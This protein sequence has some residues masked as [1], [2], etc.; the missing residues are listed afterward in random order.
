MGFRHS[1]TAKEVCLSILLLIFTSQCTE[2]ADNDVRLAGSARSFEGRVEVEF[3]GSWGTICADGWDL[4]DADVVCRQLGYESALLSQNSGRAL[5]IQDND[6]V[7]LTQVSCTGTESQ[8]SDCPGYQIQQDLTRESC[9]LDATVSCQ[10]PLYEGCYMQNEVWVERSVFIED[11]TIEKCLSACRLNKHTYGR[12]G[13]GSICQCGSDDNFGSRQASRVCSTSCPGNPLQ[14][15]GG[16]TGIYSYYRALLGSESGTYT[17]SSGSIVSPNFPGFYEAGMNGDW[18]IMFDQQTTIL[19]E[20]EFLDIDVED[21]L[22]ILARPSGD[23]ITFDSS[24]VLQE[25]RL[26]GNIFEVKFTASEDARDMFAGFWLRYSDLNVMPP[27]DSPGGM[28]TV[29]S[30]TGQECGDFGSLFSQILSPKDI[31][32]DRIL[33]Y[34]RTFDCDLILTGLRMDVEEPVT[35]NLTLWRETGGTISPIKS[36]TI[37][38]RSAAVRSVAFFPLSENDRLM[39]RKGDRISFDLGISPFL[40]AN[41]GNSGQTNF[42][43]LNNLPLDVI[44]PSDLDMMLEGG[45]AAQL[46]VVIEARERA[47]CEDVRHA[48]LISEFPTILEGDSVEVV[49]DQYYHLTNSSSRSAICGRD[50]NFDRQINCSKI[51][52]EFIGSTESLLDNRTRT[53]PAGLILLNI[54]EPFSCR[55]SVT[56]VSV[57]SE[58]NRIFVLSSWV[59]RGNAFELLDESSVSVGASDF[60][61]PGLQRNSILQ[62]ELTFLEGSILGISYTIN[63]SIIYSLGP[64]DPDLREYLVW[65]LPVGN[66]LPNELSSEASTNSS[67]AFSLRLRLQVVSKCF[68]DQLPVQAVVNASSPEVLDYIPDGFVQAGDSVTLTC[69]SGVQPNADNFQCEQ[70]GNFDVTPEC[71]STSGTSFTLLWTVLV[72]ALVV[73]GV[74][75]CGVIWLALYWLCTIPESGRKV[76]PVEEYI[77]NRR[78]SDEIPDVLPG[79]SESGSEDY[80]EMHENDYGP[81]PDADQDALPPPYDPHT[82]FFNNTLPPPRSV[83]FA[84]VPASGQQADDGSASPLPARMTPVDYADQGELQD[85]AVNTLPAQTEAPP[86]ITPTTPDAPAPDAPPPDAPPPDAP[87]PDAPPPDAPP[88]DAPPPS[89]PPPVAPRPDATLT[90]PPSP[91][92]PTVTVAPAEA[93]PLEEYVQPAAQVS[94]EIPDIPHPPPPEDWINNE[95]PQ[96]NN[97]LHRIPTTKL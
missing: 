94:D 72:M 4:N 63:N 5:T 88:A 82:D 2:C 52:P 15:C 45:E 35:F 47:R 93:S 49:C 41:P 67:R 70:T 39:I 17:D 95:L 40:A 50:G 42:I 43:I 38:T 84:N 73:L 89:A 90:P 54:G 21:K 26:A 57:Y 69:T 34:N 30:G 32:N 33:F 53:D 3:G 51:C 8:L 85:D 13:E 44:S 12:L 18:T 87:P 7:F 6:I 92:P 55:G 37:D 48:R 46:S 80:P 86:I 83:R 97:S 31:S 9:N 64:N 71:N 29:A 20:F 16:G 1:A 56:S 14:E 74:G 68:L 61:L 19:L 62:K 24:T 65:P 28:Q 81:P 78:N 10:I 96:H 77:L 91:P 66:T 79:A 59:P 60:A 58:P 27:T 75:F 22:E 25:Y 76:D 11:I 23:K 36:V